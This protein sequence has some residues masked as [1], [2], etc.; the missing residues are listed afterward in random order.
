MYQNIIVKSTFIFFVNLSINSFKD[1]LHFANT[2][3]AV[4]SLKMMVLMVPFMNVRGEDQ[5]APKDILNNMIY[6]CIIFQGN[7]I[8]CQVTKLYTHGCI[9]VEKS[10]VSSMFQN[11]N[12]LQS[13][14]S[15]SS[16]STFGLNTWYIDF[17]GR[18]PTTDFKELMVHDFMGWCKWNSLIFFNFYMTRISEIPARKLLNSSIRNMTILQR[19]LWVLN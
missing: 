4:Q 15:F 18:L 3:K 13:C 16:L 2:W 5:S 8:V 6:S 1:L 12:L 10:V 9:S 14:S 19:H 11:Y 7:E 17:V